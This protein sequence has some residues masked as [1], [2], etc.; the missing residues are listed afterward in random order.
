[1]RPMTT[2]A[3]LLDARRWRIRVLSRA[4]PLLWRPDPG[5]GSLQMV[6]L[7]STYGGW[8]VPDG[9]L[10]VDSACYCAGVG[11]DISFDLALITR[12]GARVWGL[13]PTP[14]SVRWTAEQDL[15][16]RFTHLPVGVAGSSGHLRFYAPSD[17]HH[18]SHSIKNLQRT[19]DYFTAECATIRTIMDRVGHDHLDLLKLDVEGAEHETIRTLLRDGIRPRVL[20]VEFDQPDPVLS[21]DRTVRA[22]RSAD[23]RLAKVDAFNMTFV[24]ASCVPSA[25]ARSASAST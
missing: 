22:L 11:T 12:Y 4:F 3:K 5:A 19:C 24:Q 18:V 25:A 16:P 7:G 9:V 2:T 10:D 23:Y 1:M 15:D 17:P 20:C 21:T 6:R 14:E 13:D 8:W